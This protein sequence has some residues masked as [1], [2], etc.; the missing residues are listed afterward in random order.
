ML[1]L[2]V[3]VISV[4]LTASHMGGPDVWERMREEEA[5]EEEIEA[6][7]RMDEVVTPSAN[8]F[9]SDDEGMIYSVLW[10]YVCVRV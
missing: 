6:E 4:E 10:V 7:E 9:G 2:T 1:N 5:E 8:R 3:Y